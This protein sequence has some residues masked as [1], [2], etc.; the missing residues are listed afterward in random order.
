MIHC[1]LGWREQSRPKNSLGRYDTTENL[2]N[3]YSPIISE[4]R[5]GAFFLYDIWAHQ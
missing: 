2:Y 4:V 3:N 1:Q 5:S